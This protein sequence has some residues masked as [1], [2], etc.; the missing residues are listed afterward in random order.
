ML[1]L[2]ALALVSI[3]AP[4]IAPYDPDKQSAAMSA[5]PSLQHLA[6]TDHFGRDVLSRVIWGGRDSLSIG[7]GAAVIGG[8]GS[9]VLALAFTYAGGW[10]D[11]LFQRVVDTVLALPY[12]IV[13]IVQVG[14]LGP[15]VGSIILVL[16]LRLAITGSRVIRSAVLSVK[17]QEYVSSAHVTGAGPI[18]IAVHHILPNVLPLAIVT[19]SLQVG[20]LILA[21]AA[22]SFLGLGIPPPTATWGGMMG[23]EG[24]AFLMEAPWILIAPATALS[25]AVLSANMFGDALR[26]ALDPRV[27]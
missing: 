24:R 17:Q 9:L 23:G 21:E 16:G 5:A 11:Y 14:T 1:A 10:P 20:F 18:R 8:V 15:S 25:I 22:L 19:T 3:L 12:L 2:I 7:F 27:R 6:G 26:D 13:I 4:V